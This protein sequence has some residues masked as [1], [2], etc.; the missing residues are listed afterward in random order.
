[1]YRELDKQVMNQ[2]SSFEC[3]G[4]IIWKKTPTDY[5]EDAI[6][7]INTLNGEYVVLLSKIV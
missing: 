3:L 2:T 6:K 4:S 1:M 7:N 5:A